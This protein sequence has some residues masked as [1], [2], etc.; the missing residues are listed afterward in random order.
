MCYSL[1]CHSYCYLYLHALLEGGVVG[2]TREERCS[3]VIQML[4]LPSKLGVPCS[5]VPLEAAYMNGHQPTTYEDLLTPSSDGEMYA[6][7]EFIAEGR[8]LRE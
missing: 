3:T 6:L 1:C 2:L 5:V 4:S 7:V 8:V